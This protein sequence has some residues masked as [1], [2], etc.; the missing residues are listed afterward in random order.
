MLV[1]SLGGYGVAFLFAIVAFVVLS[2]A[3]ERF[4]LQHPTEEGKG[5]CRTSGSGR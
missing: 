1:K 2:R 4:F 3:T 5:P